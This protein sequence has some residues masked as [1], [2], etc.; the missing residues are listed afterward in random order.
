MRTIR[1]LRVLFP[2]L[3][4]CDPASAQRII[5]SFS[6]TIPIGQVIL[7]GTRGTDSLPLDTVV[8]KDGGFEF[9]DRRHPSGFYQLGINDEDRIDLVLDAREPTVVMRF[10][11][12]PLQEHVQ[13]IR[14][15]ENARLWYY[16]RLSRA[17]EDSIARISSTRS[18][19]S[20][21]DTG[22]LRRLDRTEVAL[23]MST[24]RALDSLVEL[25]PEGPFAKAVRL[26]R[27]LDE[28]I[29]RSPGDIL[30]AFDLSDPQLLR[31]RS[32][33]KVILLALQG[34]MLDNELAL[35]RTCDTLL[36]A[37]ARD[38]ACWAYTRTHLCELFITYGP[39][40]VAQYIVD[41]YVTGP[42]ALVPPGVDLLKAAAAQLRVAIGSE[43]PEIE[44]VVPGSVDTVL[45]SSVLKGQRFTGLFFYSSTCDHCHDQLPGLRALTAQMD[46]GHFRLIGIALDA[47][48]EEFAATLQAEGIHWSSYS[49]LKAWGAK[50][51][52]DYNVKAT[53]SFFVIDRRGRIRAKP[54]DH[55]AL[56]AFLASNRE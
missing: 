16:K 13:V 47:S 39:D 28:F 4:V 56:R 42:G 29:G 22:L 48:A 26:D 12:R 44:L 5:G 2:F 50:S 49:E 53:P 37:A 27:A 10:A 31:S 9:P 55:D 23:R 38:T 46:P 8:V 11:G 36:A 32:F 34:T 30:A 1:L 6:D 45:L 14:S 24:L 15:P 18:N 40:E 7:Y 54:L 33:D 21:L 35:Q 19:A 3:D 20:P 52:K 43:A 51:A 41:H 17:R 25:A